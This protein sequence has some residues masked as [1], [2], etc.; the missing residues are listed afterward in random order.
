M[1]Q[2]DNMQAKVT[3]VTGHLTKDR[4]VRGTVPVQNSY[5]TRVGTLKDRILQGPTESD[6]EGSFYG[7]NQKTDNYYPGIDD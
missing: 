2:P 3:T 5:S 7:Y 6:A 1:K 4:F